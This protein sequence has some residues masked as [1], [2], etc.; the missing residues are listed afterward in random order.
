[1]PT[2]PLNFVNIGPR[3]TFAASGK[4]ATTSADIDALFAA[5]R[6][7]GS[8]KL[9]LHFH[10]GLV[11]EDA[12]MTRAESMRAV[13]EAAGCHPVMFVWETGFVETLKSNLDDINRTELY[14]KV[15]FWVIKKAGKHLDLTAGGKGS[16]GELDDAYIEAQL[17][18]AAPFDET[19]VGAGARGG[20]GPLSIAG[21]AAKE[22]EIQA[23]LE[24]E[25]ASDPAFRMLLTAPPA[26]WDQVA[27][28]QLAA[29]EV[30]GGK[31]LI[32]LGTA[33]VAVARVTVRVLER[34][35]RRRDHG[36]FPTVVEEILRALYLDH[37]GEWVWGG[38]K[39]S[40]ESMWL[41]NTGV[42]GDS[43]HAGRYFLECLA[44]LQEETAITVD[45]I[46]H[47]AGAIAI[48]HLLKTAA[49]DMPSVKV[50]N[51]VLLAPAARVELFH[52]EIVSKPERYQALRLF[53]MEDAMEV[54]DRLVGALYSRSLLYFIS[55]VLEGGED[56]PLCGLA[57]HLFDN[58]TYKDAPMPAIRAFLVNHPQNRLVLS[59]S[60]VLSAAAALG[61]RSD[62]KA[63]GGF[64]QEKLTRE[65][66][67]HILSKD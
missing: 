63:H 33:V 58:D 28:E 2:S 51:I 62:A 18:T 29:D 40:A 12:G 66:L 49:A 31:G 44:K 53:T 47:S 38:M 30:D 60:S 39:R 13:Y 65:S 41:S 20:G 43:R 42:S 61:L 27:A 14:R 15:L 6:A 36:F 59:C 22:I 50:R 48:C 32:E 34:F 67:T 64:D 21:L 8:K 1:M 57:R 4:V 26:G 24:E 25:M 23:E 55:G 7:Q 45:L 56:V 10:G 35:I 37:F 54:Q 19:G 11:N 52:D 9:A 46:G 5:L 3:G 16:A 17:E